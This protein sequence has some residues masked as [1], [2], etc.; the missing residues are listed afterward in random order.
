[1]RFLCMI[2]IALGYLL[3]LPLHLYQWLFSLDHS[4]VLKKLGISICVHK[5]FGKQSCSEYSIAQLKKEGLKSL[6]K[7]LKRI[8]SCHSGNTRYFDTTESNDT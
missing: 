6:P 8:L 3:T 2:N 4:P 5:A 7:I 1:M